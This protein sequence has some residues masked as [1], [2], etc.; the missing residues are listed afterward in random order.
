MAG[1]ID[2]WRIG[3]ESAVSYLLSIGLKL[4]DR[5]WRAGRREIDII[6][7][8]DFYIHFIEV[9][10]L[11]VPSQVKPYETLNFRKKSNVMIAA[12]SYLSKYRI[13]KEVSFDFVSVEVSGDKILNLEFFPDAFKS[14]RI[15]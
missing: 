14:E 11:S 4:R 7:E 8:D 15:K 13:N 10:T 1:K 5:N 9:R 6:M 2:V 12:A 3:E